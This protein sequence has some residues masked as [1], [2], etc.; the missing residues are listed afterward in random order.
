[1]TF[2]ASYN[3][4][5]TQVNLSN[6]QVGGDYPFLN[7]LKTAQAWSYINNASAPVTPDL[8]DT[9]GYPT[10]IVNT[11]FY[12]VFYVPPQSERPGN[13]VITWTG[14]GTVFCGMSNTLVSGSKTGS[15]GSG[16][17]VFS[18]TDNRFLV[19]ISAL[20]VTNLQVFHASDETALNAGQVFGVRFKQRLTEANFGVIR[21][22]NWQSGN[23][24]NIT[25]WASRRSAS[26]VFYSGYEVRNALFAGTTTNTGNAYVTAAFPSIH[27]SDGT[28]WTSGAPKDKD[29]VHIVFGASATPSGTCSLDIGTTGTA[30]N[31]LGA[32]CAVLSSGA[33]TYP[34]AGTFQSMA[35]LVYDAVLN[36]WIKQGG[37]VARGSAGLGT[38]VPPELM[39]QLC[40]EVGAHPYFVAPPLA[41]TPM[42]DWHTQLATYIKNNGPS[43]MVPRFEGCNECW[44][45]VGGDG[46]GGFYQTG[47]AN[48]IATAYTWGA[49]YH[50]WYGKAL[51]TIGQA[52]NAVYGG[53]PSTQTSYQV[54]CG[55][56]TATGG[57][58]STSNPRLAST[59]YL[60][61]VPQSGY[62]S[63]PGV[64]EAWR[65]ATH[66]CCTQYVTPS[67][68]N[69]ATETMLA[70][71]F[72]GKAFT[73]SIASGVMTVTAAKASASAN[74]AVGDTIFGTQIFQVGGGVPSGVTISS[75]GS[76]TGTML[77]TYNLSQAITVASQNM[78][79]ATDL[80]APNT[81]ADTTNSG[82]GSFTISAVSTLYGQWKTWAQGF[83]I[84]KMCGYEG[85]YS[86]DYTN[87]NGNSSVDMLKSASK[88]DTNLLQFTM[89]NYNNFINLSVG[90]FTS[91]FPSCFQ[92]SGNPNIN[93]YSGSAWSVL[94]D[95]YQAPDPPQW[96][97]IKL[98]NARK[99]RFT[100]ST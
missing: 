95:V 56:Q 10:T 18:T 49:D 86:P 100:I 53:T 78:T 50:N 97:A 45:T 16:R 77:G 68:Y 47:Y 75:F 52:V 33:N 35:T 55:V 67:D 37:D 48:A 84:Q 92:L 59:K 93:G 57:S 28:S 60:G 83:S 62:S 51:S 5:R 11:G 27:S 42:T 63:A 89:T 64:A 30:I 17:Y 61:T 46:S 38:G 23:T 15:G 91:E 34:V 36:A 41:C 71:N 40:G 96:T 99:R 87:A 3:G 31:I 98:F 44:N 1:M 20:P 76:G 14:N 43:W 29:T 73:A 2:A 70:T 94:E 24:T 9:N 90:G 79:G 26:Y 25:N 85:G 80:T 12:T 66:V 19:G 13:Y 6:I 72:A 22:L 7:C 21:F 74:F 32:S 69:T 39:V 65:W 54:I 4:G 58:A 82:G 81:Y 88:L 8:L